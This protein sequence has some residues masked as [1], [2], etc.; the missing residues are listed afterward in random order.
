MLLD[1]S[2]STQ[3]VQE[4]VLT[5]MRKHLMTSEVNCTPLGKT[6]LLFFTFE[7]DEI[8]ANVRRGF[9]RLGVEGL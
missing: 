6:V 1:T 9:E 3:G 7:G 8:D 2:A 5:E 4:D